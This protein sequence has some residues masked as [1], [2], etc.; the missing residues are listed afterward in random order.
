MSRR[1]RTTRA[2][3]GKKAA[4]HRRWSWALRTSWGSWATRR[5]GC[6]AR[7]PTAAARAGGRRRVSRWFP[8]SHG[9]S[10]A[11]RGESVRA[12]GLTEGRCDHSEHKRDMRDERREERAQDQSRRRLGERLRRVSYCGERERERDGRRALETGQ[13]ATGRTRNGRGR[14]PLPSLCRQALSRLSRAWVSSR[15]DLRAQA[16]CSAPSA[17]CVCPSLGLGRFPL[18]STWGRSS[19]YNMTIIHNIPTETRVAR[20]RQ[21]T[22]NRSRVVRCARCALICYLSK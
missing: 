21:I 8:G 12:T 14:P 15:R 16:L 1:W 9:R 11:M 10:S 4:A 2:C 6:S 3:G 5:R 18:R 19:S 13:G 20:A 17:G 7:E 22:I